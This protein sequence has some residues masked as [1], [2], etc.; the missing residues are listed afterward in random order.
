[1]PIDAGDEEI[2]LDDSHAFETFLDTYS[3]S[4]DEEIPMEPQSED[5]NEFSEAENDVHGQHDDSNSGYNEDE[6]DD[7]ADDNFENNDDDNGEN[8]GDEDDHDDDD[9]ND[10]FSRLKSPATTNDDDGINCFTTEPSFDLEEVKARV[11][12]IISVLSN[13][14]EKRDPEKSRSD[15]TEQL[16]KDLMLVYGYNEFLMEKI[17]DLFEVNELK[18]FLDAS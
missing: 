7:D 4:E 12:K 2:H 17:M 3:A 16:K 18:E 5:E 13:F 15:Y 11:E 6:P 9:D 1:M 8:D 10:G 14:A